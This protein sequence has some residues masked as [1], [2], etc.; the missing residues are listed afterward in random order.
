MPRKHYSTTA[1]YFAD[2]DGAVKSRLLALRK[3]ILDLAPDGT[4]ETI[5]YNIPCF[6]S[7]KN[8][9]YLAGF[10]HHISL[11]PVPSLAP[12][13]QPLIQHHQKGKGTLQFAHSEPLPVEFIR[14]V[15]TNLL[16][17]VQ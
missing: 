11:Y 7:G 4:V 13:W 10:P 1:E 5:S 3:H 9:V 2:F 14:Q 16:V 15:V 8:R 17:G 6:I 12:R